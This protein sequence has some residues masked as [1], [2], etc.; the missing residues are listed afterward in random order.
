MTKRAPKLT[1][2]K[3][4]KIFDVSV[5]RRLEKL[6]TQHVRKFYD[7]SIDELKDI[8]IDSLTKAEEDADLIAHGIESSAP[9]R[10]VSHCYGW[11]V[12]VQHDQPAKLKKVIARIPG[13]GFSPKFKR[14]FSDAAKLKCDWINFDR[15]A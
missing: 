3:T 15:D 9:M 6:D 2:A 8:D 14:L 10:V 11:W 7:V 12:S 1:D 13:Y 5:S 4:W